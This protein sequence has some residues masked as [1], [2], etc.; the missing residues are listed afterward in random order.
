MTQTLFS[1]KEP[2]EA[3][4]HPAQKIEAQS[5]K[6]FIIAITILI[7]WLVSLIFLLSANVSN[8]SI[9]LTGKALIWQSLLYT[10]LFITAHD[11]M[12][13]AVFP[14]NLKANNAIGSL[15]VFC[16]GLFSYQ[17]LLRKHWL[18]HK[19]PATQRDPDFHNGSRPNVFIWYFQFMKRYWNWSR[20]AVLVL[21]LGIIHY[22]LH[23]SEANLALF[24]VIPSILSSVQLFYF[25]TYLPHREPDTGY[26]NC[27]R[28]Q[29]TTF[30]LIWS[31]LTCYH[32]GYHEEHHEYPHVP[33][34]HLPKIYQLKQTRHSQR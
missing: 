11:A 28:A 4:E 9:W 6:G 1:L 17:E 23:V 31:F 24:W 5:I 10:G 32:F 15:S 27:H 29:S 13:G 33:W 19:Y 2:V 7:L 18:H 8:F 14:V 34:W 16:Y 20:T 25:G 12:H 30:P 22:L 3:I 26:S 21:S